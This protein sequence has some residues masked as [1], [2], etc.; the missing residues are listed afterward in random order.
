MKTFQKS[1][2]VPPS[3]GDKEASER[4]SRKKNEPA[5]AVPPKSSTLKN[6]DEDPI[7]CVIADTT[8]GRVGERLSLCEKFEREG[9]GSTITVY[10]VWSTDPKPWT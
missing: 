5:K 7:E 1:V 2:C 3:T 6:G 9:V 8:I 10:I 4:A